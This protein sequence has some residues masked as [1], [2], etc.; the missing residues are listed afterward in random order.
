MSSSISSI[1][2][3]PR[4]PEVP[5]IRPASA[6]VPRRWKWLLAFL[7]VVLV[8]PGVLVLPPVWHGVLR[9]LLVWQASRGG[10]ELKIH[11]LSGGLFQTVRLDGVRLSRRGVSPEG[12]GTALRIDRA[13]FVV[14]WRLPWVHRSASW[15]K[16][17]R[18]EGVRGSVDLE[19]ALSAD[20]QES[21]RGN[22]AATRWLPASF[23]IEGDDLRLRQSGY[24]VRLSGWRLTGTRDGTGEIGAREIRVDG[25][26]VGSRF[27]GWHGRTIWKDQRLTISGS[28]SDGGTSLTR[29]TLDASNLGRRWLDWDCSLLAL[30]G[31]V[32]GQGSINF[33]GPRLAVEV[34]ATLRRTALAPIARLLG[35]RGPVDGQVEEASFTFRGEPDNLAAA[36]MWLSARSTGFQWGNR[37]WQSLETQAVVVNRR[38]QLNRFDLRQDGNQLSL[39][40]EYPLP[41]DD[42]AGLP[43]TGEGG[44][45]QSAGFSCN[46]DARLEDLHALAGLLGPV[47]PELAGRMSINGRLN[48]APGHADVEGYLNVEGTRLNVCGAPL[49]YLRSTLLFRH[50]VLE[51]ADV[52]ATHDAD[53]FTAHGVVG[54]S[55]DP[56]DRR[57][58]L[59][60]EIKDM[61]VYAPALTRLP[62]VSEKA[63]DIRHLN[64]VLRVDGGRLFFDQWEGERADDFLAR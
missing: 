24:I 50:G 32:R 1:A 46:V 9:G 16:E 31:E 19:S 57:G 27:A 38:V 43:W 39:S 47:T 3:L 12:E 36:Q 2:T 62:A 25:P 23:L 22:E 4:S 15:L 6:R 51:V 60:A 17:V 49:D 59:R 21:R 40:G 48:A 20:K 10:Y 53:Y 44:W 11:R 41:P 18:L 28:D 26:G 13:D 56:T 42:V 35:V 29:A 52:Q 55:G 14:A 45:W 7:V 61:S 5:T 34:A 58:E 8:A 63:A 37:R 54:L 33:S 64:A 30:G